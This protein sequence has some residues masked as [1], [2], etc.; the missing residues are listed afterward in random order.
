MDKKIDN[1]LD[2]IQQELKGF[3]RQEIEIDKLEEEKREYTKDRH[4]IAIEIIKDAKLIITLEDENI[5]LKNKIEELQQ[6]LLEYK[7]TKSL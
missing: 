7:Y 4:L 5:R 2:T 1:A 6:L 3:T